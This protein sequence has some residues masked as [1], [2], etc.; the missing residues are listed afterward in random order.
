MNGLRESAIKTA[1]LG[2][3]VCGEADDKKGVSRAGELAQGLRALGVLPEVLCS[4]PSIH[5]AV[6]NCQ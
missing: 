4:S 3:V 6:H 1:T 5:M 2:A